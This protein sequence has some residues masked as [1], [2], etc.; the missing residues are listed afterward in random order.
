MEAPNSQQHDNEL[1]ICT[2]SFH[3]AR[4]IV[5]NWE[6]ATAL[7]YDEDRIQWIVAEN[8]PV[9][10]RDRLDYSDSRFRVIPG[11]P[12][13]S[14]VS[15]HHTE[16]LH[17]ALEHVTT[18]FLL[19]LDPDFYIIRPNWWKEVGDHMRARDLAIFGAPWHPR[20]TDKFRYFP[21]VHCTFIDLSKM[22]LRDLDFRP[23]SGKVSTFSA[24]RDTSSWFARTWARITLRHRQRVSADSG[25]RMFLRYASDP[26]VKSECLVPVYRVPQDLPGGVPL[27]LRSRLIERIL[28]D[29]LCYVPK[30]R[31]YFTG[32]GFRES[33]FW[34][35]MPEDWEEFLWRN[36]PF[37]FHVRRNNKKQ[38]RSEEAEL[39]SL[40]S[41]LKS[42]I[43]NATLL[44]K[45]GEEIA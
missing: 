29:S 45:A 34:D 7:T 30:R 14:K 1:T 8:T 43:D 41:L 17:R 13:I 2:V 26:N 44:H 4:H 42:I 6:L 9:G 22:N 11:A 27:P 12:P 20:Y 40:G 23:G 3:N 18:R 10:G 15:Y 39:A 24:R 36:E 37:G 16:G 32:R 25:T 35:S 38:V 33:G 19:V 21:T 5:L 31:G 28:P